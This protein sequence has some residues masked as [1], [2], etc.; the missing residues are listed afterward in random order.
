MTYGAHARAL[1]SLGVPLIGSQLG[2]FAINATDTIMLGWYSVEALAALV[3]AHGLFFT[4]FVV[5]AGF[6]WAVMPMVAAAAESNDQV[7]VRRVTRMGFWVSLVY[8]ALFMPV[9]L[10][11][12]PFFL[13]LGQDPEVSALAGQY[14]QIAAW[15][16]VPALMFMV[17]RSYLAALNRTS[18]VFWTTVAAAVLNAFFNYVLIFGEF[19]APELGVRGA[20]IASVAMHAASLGVM[21]LYA[22]R[23]GTGHD[24]FARVW[25]PDWGA[26]DQVFRLG[27]PIGVTNLAEVGLFSAAAVFV[28][29]LGPDVL[30]AHGIA[31]QLATATFMI[32]IGLSQAATIRAGRAY[33]RKDRDFLRRGALVAITMSACVAFLTIVTFLS[34]PQFLIGLFLDPQDP[35]R[36]VIIAVGVHLLAAAAL[37]QFADGMQVMTLGLLRGVQDTRVPMVL[38]ALSYW[39]IGA[40]AGLL[41]GFPLGL[42]GVGVWLG[43]FAGLSMAAVLMSLRFWRRS[44]PAVGHI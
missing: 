19:G 15:G 21:A 23:L 18:I 1:L 38:A 29:W 41:L 27:W 16:L 12:E 35:A 32:H 4:V 6:A 33:G 7:Q 11:A 5:G 2:Q 26:L 40:P 37:F 24:L 14:L 44:L 30:A 13:M 17:L 20:A 3:L 9:M 25:R 8:A 22:I 31:L 28:G 34:V 43:L 10:L 36:P 39:V 42:G